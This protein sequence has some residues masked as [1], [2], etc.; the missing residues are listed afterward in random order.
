MKKIFVFLGILMVG[1]SL[2]AADGA[3]AP[4][5][6][7]SSMWQTL[8]MIGI[9]VVFFYFIL[10]RPEQRRRKAMEQKRSSMKKGD[11]ITAMGI[12]GTIDKIKEQTVIV[13]MVDGAKIEFL[14]GAISEVKPKEEV[15][16][17]E[18]EKSSTTQ[19]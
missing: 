17:E 16:E 13:K 19:S 8:I 3:T 4:I 15:T 9:A 12:V 18:E 11:R 5:K 6:T 2:W 10:W 1:C 14:K 7:Q